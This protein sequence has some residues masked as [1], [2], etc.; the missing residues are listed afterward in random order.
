MPRIRR[1]HPV[2]H[3]FNRDREIQSLRKNF[4]DWMGYVWLEMLSEADRSNG[5]VKGDRRSI[6]ESYTWLSLSMK[7]AYYIHTILRALEYMVDRGWIRE[8]EGGFLVHN[9]AEYHKHRGIKESQVGTKDP[10]SLTRPNLTVPEQNLLKEKDPP[11]EAPPRGPMNG[12]DA[13]WQAYPQKQ[14][15]D[16]AEESWRKKTKGVPIE[17]I[18]EGIAKWGHSQKWA[19][20]F[21]PLPA[22][23]LNQGRWKDDPE[24][25]RQ[26]STS[27]HRTAQAAKRLIDRK[28]G[29]REGG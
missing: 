3:D 9:Y 8:V 20:G 24:P 27:A 13:F 21:V 12:F 18:L 15:K 26:I 19:E 4:A 6:A 5:L 2:S 28:E 11:L 29:E 14:G 7:P 23:W 22:T 17:L 25:A 16:K 1:W 10:P